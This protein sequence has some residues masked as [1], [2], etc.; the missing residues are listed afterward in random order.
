MACRYTGAFYL[1]DILDDI[2]IDGVHID[3][4]TSIRA[5]SFYIKTVATKKINIF[6]SSFKNLISEISHAPFFL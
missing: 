1:Q 5:P 2:S 6:K 4:G 3:N